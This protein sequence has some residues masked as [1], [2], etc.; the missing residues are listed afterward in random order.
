MHVAELAMQQLRQAIQVS[1]Y[2]GKGGRQI[3]I[4]SL[5]LFDSRIPKL[6][7]MLIGL[8]IAWPML[9]PVV[10]SAFAGF[11]GYISERLL[12]NGVNESLYL[13]NSTNELTVLGSGP[14]VSTVSATSSSSGG[15]VTM[16]MTGNLQSLNGM[17]DADVWFEWD[18]SFGAWSNSTA[19]VNTS[20]TGNKTA[21]I[22]PDAG[23]NVFYRFVSSTDGTSYGS[24]RYLPVVGGGHGVSYWLI[25]T[26]L[27][28]IVAG[29]ILVV[30]FRATGNPLKAFMLA[31]VGLLVFYCILIISSFL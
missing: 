19:V 10:V 8:I 14:V 17:P 26:L 12:G 21:V 24:V 16:T 31:V 6:L 7:V 18:Y 13:G 3:M 15:V 9:S 11:G 23:K 27:P 2:G 4:C 5:R 28:V 25:N 1:P 29:F 20:T 30:V 22:N